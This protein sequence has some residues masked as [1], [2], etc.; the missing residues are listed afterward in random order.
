[1][2]PDEVF[3]TLV[4]LV[5]GPALWALWLW[6]LWRLPLRREGRA[7]RLAI[8]NTLGICALLIYIVLRTAASFDVVGAPQ[9]VFMYLVLGLA[10]VRIVETTFIAFGLSVRDDVVE[11]RNQ[12]AGAAVTGALV[13]A[14]LCY[15]GANIGDGPGWWVVVFSAGV[16][17]VTWLLAWFTLAFF[18]PV[19]DTVT[20]DRDRAAGLRLGA[21]L[22]SWGLI[23]GRAVAGD[24]VSADAT[25]NEFVV[26]ALPPVLLILAVALVIEHRARPNAERPQVALLPW[27]V[28]P[29]AAYVAIAMAVVARAGVP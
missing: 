20:V 22:A 25:V 19:A 21:L 12:A 15:A 26:L 27:G 1:M 17:T 9:Y 2:S 24:W 23:L 18:S 10:W 6:R 3:V 11:R 4:A 7:P 14:T 5:T 8:T 29:A 16:A 13:G 28:L